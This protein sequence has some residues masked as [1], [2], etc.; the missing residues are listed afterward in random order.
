MN[1]EANQKERQADQA[2]SSSDRGDQQNR[3]I[4]RNGNRNTRGRRSS[5][6]IGA[7]GQALPERQKSNAQQTDASKG[8]SQERG[9]YSNRKPGEQSQQQRSRPNSN[10]RNDRRTNRGPGPRTGEADRF[11][12]GGAPRSGDSRRDRNVSRQQG[13]SS[14]PDKRNDRNREPRNWGRHLRSEETSEDI[15][16]ENERIEKEIWLEIADIHTMKLD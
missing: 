15:R 11:G 9:N 4:S 1:E 3:P 6:P 2:G 14:V 10:Y 8:K 5:R 12:D 13:R 7:Q 16:V